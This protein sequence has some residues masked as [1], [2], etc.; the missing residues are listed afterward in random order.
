MTSATTRLGL[1]HTC[2]CQLRQGGT[3]DSTLLNRRS[4]AKTRRRG[5]RPTSGTIRN[6]FLVPHCSS[7][8]TAMRRTFPPCSRKYAWEQLRGD[9]S[10]YISAVT[11]ETRHAKSEPCHQR[12]STQPCTSLLEERSLMSSGV[13]SAS[14]SVEAGMSLCRE[15]SRCKLQ[16]QVRN[17]FHG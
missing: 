7:S 6:A 8:A 1:T 12:V 4:P 13:P 5:F 9:E 14:R 10:L 3:S 2:L 16:G 17:A 15:W 11:R